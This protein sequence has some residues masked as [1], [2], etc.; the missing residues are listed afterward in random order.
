MHLT[1]KTIEPRPRLLIYC[2]QT[3]GGIAEHAHYQARAAQRLGV[4]ATVL[5]AP[6]FLADGRSK[7]YEVRERLFKTNSGIKSPW[8][9]KS[10]FAFALLLNY[11]LLALW[12]LGSR[13]R[14]V[15]F[16]ASS[17]TLALVWVWPLLLLSKLGTKFAVNI[18]DPER[19]Q[20]GQFKF[21][22]KLSVTMSLAPFK[23]GLLNEDSAADQPDIPPHIHRVLVPYGR[24]DIDLTKSDGL[25]LREKIAPNGSGRHVYLSFGY[26]VDRKNLDLFMHAMVP[27]SD[28]A[29]I[30][31]G[32]NGASGDRPDTFYK[33]LAQELGIADRVRIDGGFVDSRKV[34]DYFEAADAILLAY[35]REFVSQSG[36]LLVAANWSKPVL[37]SSGEGPL[38]STVEKFGL[39]IT[40][41]PDSVEEMKRGLEAMRR[42]QFD[43]SGWNKFR[44][45]A[46]WESNV[47]LLFA[48]L[49]CNDTLNETSACELNVSPRDGEPHP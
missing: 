13:A 34:V 22:H 36:V 38:R 49:Y 18:H 37:A 5:T 33:K 25:R 12:I 43:A 42:L 27:H 9:R 19:K 44:V 7:P 3:E 4:A 26:I 23:I 48:A 39:G 41:A 8:R 45:H 47:R 6:G 24:Y 35:K 46:S 31:A 10:Y 14:H 28:V 2:P 17:E 32:P 30:I 1:T 15:L 20:R 11:F 29:L 21:L 16:S 40:V